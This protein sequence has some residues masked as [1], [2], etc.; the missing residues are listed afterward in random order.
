MLPLI[1]NIG[2]G[3]NKQAN[4]ERNKVTRELFQ[5]SKDREVYA[6]EQNTGAVYHIKCK[7]AVARNRKLDKVQTRTNHLG[8]RMNSTMLALFSQDYSEYQS[9]DMK[10]SCM[11]QAATVLTQYERHGP[12]ATLLR[13]PPEVS[14]SVRLHRRC[15]RHGWAGDR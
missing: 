1:V 2:K 10:C 12:V 5:I 13:L 9:R 4:Q 3:T 11:R 14:I 15:A 8:P 6:L 7:P